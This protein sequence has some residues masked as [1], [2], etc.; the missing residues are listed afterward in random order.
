ML[1]DSD[2][3]CTS[4]SG[5]STSGSIAG[6][7]SGW[8]HAQQRISAWHGT[9]STVAGGL[10]VGGSSSSSG[11]LAA[12][13]DSSSIGS[14]GISSSSTRSFAS[15]AA[16][17]KRRARERAEVRAAEARQREA[18]VD[19]DSDDD[20]EEVDGGDG[21]EGAGEG[22]RRRGRGR[23]RKPK[24]PPPSD[25]HYRGELD[26]GHKKLEFVL[27]LARRR[28]VGDA[29][30]QLARC[31][32]RAAA[33]VRDAVREAR[34]EAVEAGADAARLYVKAAWTGRSAPLKRPFYHG[35]GYSSIRRKRRTH[36]WVEVAELPAARGAAAALLRRAGRPARLQ[37]PAMLRPRR[38]RRF[39]RAPAPAPAPRQQQQA[40]T[41]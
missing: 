29:L 12:S 19:A 40:V 2:E 34:D 23:G 20:E 33:L 38:E 7:P 30:A 32:K 41:A 25:A 1:A 36:L 6:W 11:G 35:R 17:A 3:L 39:P 13:I 9:C 8:P 22:A 37:T 16:A 4:T 26:T 21:D 18:W 14:I 10:P 24:P 5:R 31:P 27:P 28:L 15:A